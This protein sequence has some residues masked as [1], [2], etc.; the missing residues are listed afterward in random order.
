MQLI[1]R[2]HECVLDGAEQFEETPCYT[3]FSCTGYCGKYEND[4][5]FFKYNHWNS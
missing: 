4:A 2:S 3:I 1:I 5:S